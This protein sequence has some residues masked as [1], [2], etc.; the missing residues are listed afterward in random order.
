MFECPVQPTYIWL[1]PQNNLHLLGCKSGHI[2]RCR[3][4]FK[5]IIAHDSQ[6]ILI[7]IHMR[8]TYLIYNSS[9]IRDCDKDCPLNGARVYTNV[10]LHHGECIKDSCSCVFKVDLYICRYFE[11]D[12]ELVGVMKYTDLLHRPNC[13]GA[14]CCSCTK[15]LLERGTY[16][17]RCEVSGTHLN[18]CGAERDRLNDW[19]KMSLENYRWPKLIPY[20]FE[21]FIKELEIFWIYIFDDR[22]IIFDIC[23][24]CDSSDQELS[25]S[26]EE[27]PS[28]DDII[29]SNNE[30]TS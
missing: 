25:S 26:D 22:P 18:P 21:E 10:F 3:E 11:D 24:D 2:C 1:A 8:D 20:N 23:I 5:N 19:A 9:R 4:E 12:K 27:L 17:L 6:F 28:L 15:R 30:I 14:S 29:I 13:N 16:E 7:L